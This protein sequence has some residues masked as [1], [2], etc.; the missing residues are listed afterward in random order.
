MKKRWY[1]I[2]AAVLLAIT[3]AVV[4]WL[5]INRHYNDNNPLCHIP[6]SAAIVLKING[7]NAYKQTVATTEYSSYYSNLFF[8][9]VVSSVINNAIT[10]IDS[11]ARSEY[12]Y[13]RTVYISYHAQPTDTVGKTLLVFP[14][15]NYLDGTTIIDAVEQAA[16]LSTTRLSLDGHNVL[17]ADLHSLHFYLT[18]NNECLFATDDAELLRSVLLKNQPV[19]ADDQCFGTLE[20]TTSP[21]VPL[22]VFVNVA[23]MDSLAIFDP[24]TRTMSAWGNWLELDMDISSQMINANG[25][26]I[27][28][29]PT[30][31]T[32]MA[33]HKPSA[34]GI[35][36]MIPS[37]AQLFYAVA[38]SKRGSADEQYV[39]QLQIDG[40]WDGYQRQCL[41]V[42][43][44][45][46]IDVES[47]MAK[48]FEGEM[49]L[50]AFNESIGK[51]GEVCLV[52]NEKNGT[53]SQGELNNIISKLR[54]KPAPQE[55]DVVSPIPSISIPIYEAF[56]DTANMFFLTDIYGY[57]PHK[58]YLRYENTLMFAD[59][60]SVLKQTLTE[61]LQNR[62]YAN[63]ANFRSF[64]NN[65]SSENISFIYCSS[66]AMR[67]ITANI[68]T[69][70]SV[71]YLNAISDFYGFGMQLSNLSDLPY[72]TASALYEPNK[73]NVLGNAK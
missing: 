69:T 6:S 9:D 54:N 32:V 58:Y 43:N 31:F 42:K 18:I 44:A 20:R 57:V 68:D 35:D 21:S 63:D 70:T 55:A 39:H 24:I 30:I 12:I 50:F 33:Q 60:L 22:S 11:I 66:K 59:T 3:A 51:D 49:A 38:A 29:K 1:A 4:G 36:N 19:L 17:S 40:R 72:L 52:V 7:I 37:S 73:S 62:T 16:A 26:L 64:R 46:G 2:G 67:S 25:F 71:D 48:V 27:S 34:F 28:G 8:A 23:S 10:A 13:N 56:P 65:F 45:V 47:E 5:N 41:D 15:E 61:R 14:L 53:I